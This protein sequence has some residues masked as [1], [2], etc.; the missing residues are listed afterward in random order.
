[1]PRIEWPVA[2]GRPIVQ[3]EL[4]TAQGTSR[5]R[6]LLADTGAGTLTSLFDVVLGETDCRACSGRPFGTIS[7]RGA[8]Q[9]N[10]L[11]YMVRLRV[12]Q[13]K[14]DRYVRAVAAP[15]LPP[16]LDGIAGFRFLSQF[17]Y[18]NLG[19]RDTFGSEVP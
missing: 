1:M 2:D 12:A 16:G 5:T 6:T 3:V 17:T 7:L 10:H 13:L 9:G 4:E 14:F 15:S 18:G 11:V 19:G 8:F